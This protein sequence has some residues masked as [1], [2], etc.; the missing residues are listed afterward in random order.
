MILPFSYTFYGLLVLS[1]SVRS[2]LPMEILLLWAVGIEKAARLRITSL[3]VGSLDRGLSGKDR[4]GLLLQNV[5]SVL[6]L[7][8]HFRNI[9]RR[10]GDAH[11][12]DV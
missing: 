12:D 2:K 4:T 11:S 8:F 1:L 5:P 7:Q 6:S 10:T 3:H 9:Y